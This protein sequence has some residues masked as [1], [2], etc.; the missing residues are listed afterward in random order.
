MQDEDQQ[1]GNL[2]AE[3]IQKAIDTVKARSWDINP[4][5]VADELKVSRSAIYRHADIMKLIIAARGGGFGMDVQTSLDLAWQLRQLEQQNNELKEKLA[6]N[7]THKK[8]EVVQPAEEVIEKMVPSSVEKADN[9]EQIIFNIANNGPDMNDYYRQLAQLSWKDIETVYYFRVSSI[10]DYVKN[11]LSADS[12]PH[13]G[14]GEGV[15]KSLDTAISYGS[16]IG[17]ETNTGSKQPSVSPFAKLK[18]SST[19]SSQ[20]SR[21]AGSAKAVAGPTLAKLLDQAGIDIPQVNSSVRAPKEKTK[22]Q[23]ID[24]QLERLTGDRPIIEH[25]TQINIFATDMSRVVSNL[26]RDLAAKIRSGLG[27]EDSQLTVPESQDSDGRVSGEFS[28]WQSFEG[29]KSSV[30]SENWQSVE[31]ASPA[32]MQ[33]HGAEAPPIEAPIQIEQPQAKLP[34]KEDKLE[35]QI[36]LIPLLKDKPPVVQSIMPTAE[37]SVE[38]SVEEQDKSKSDST[39]L[40]EAAGSGDE[41]RDLIQSHIRNAAEQMAEFSHGHSIGT[42][43]EFEVWLNNPSRSKFVGSTKSPESPAEEEP[44]VKSQDKNL[45][46]KPRVVPPEVRKA[47]LILGVRPDKIT[48]EIVQESWKKAIAAPGVHPDLGGDTEL[49]VYLNT[50][51]DVL[52]R[53]LDAQAP[54]LGKKFGPF[55]S[56]KNSKPKSVKPEDE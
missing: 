3:T 2:S 15:E 26:H 34:D 4:F 23:D 40:D 5:T 31:G 29:P 28:G 50:A 52:M 22:P 33:S 55:K 27:K 39:N 36:K 45:P 37:A 6:V 25:E 56:E 53:F 17:I 18:S 51:K 9:G 44:E 7:S 13:T 24:L 41:L 35:P 48:Y 54:K 42:G 14:N 21:D 47:C 32:Q 12:S 1:L 10:K 16:L 19:G 49:A 43:K 38:K 11:L 30:K 20:A 46:F 8:N